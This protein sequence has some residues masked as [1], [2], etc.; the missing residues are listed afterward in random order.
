[1]YNIGIIGLGIV[2]NSI[3][4]F[5]KNK[6]EYK[7]FFYDKYK[8]INNINIILNT[9]Y[10]FLCLPTLFDEEINEY[11]K[12]EVYNVCEFLSKNNYKGIIF[13]KSTVEPN[14]TNNLYTYNNNT[15]YIFI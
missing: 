8:K 12:E 4:N 13:L 2:G 6:N 11:N 9:D 5:F 15:I 7:L 14:T 10:L 1:M 3:Q